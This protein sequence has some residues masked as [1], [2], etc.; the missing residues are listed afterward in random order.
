MGLRDAIQGPQTNDDPF[1]S[2]AGPALHPVSFVDLVEV[3]VL[4]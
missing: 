2:S 3:S 4:Q 1:T